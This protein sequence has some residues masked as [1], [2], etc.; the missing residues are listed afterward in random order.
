ML[1]VKQRLLWNW[2]VVSNHQTTELAKV[3]RG[4]GILNVC[5]SSGNQNDVLRVE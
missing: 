3:T 4:I 1:T 2:A 5:V